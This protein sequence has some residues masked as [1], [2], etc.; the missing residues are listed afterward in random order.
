LF[1]VRDPYNN[2]F[3]II[4][5]STW[6]KNENKLT[7]GTY[8]AVIG[9]TDMNRSIDFYS[10]I[11][12]YDKVVFDQSTV[13]TEFK[14]IPGGE[15]KLRRV[16]LTHSQ[17]RLGA[18]S[19]LFGDTQIELIQALDRQPTKIFADRLWGDLGFIHLCFDMTGM[20]LM[21]EACKKAGCPFTVDTGDSFDMG[22]ASGAFSY[23]EDPDG[24]LIEFVETHKIPVI[25]KLGFYISLRKRNPKKPL[26]KWML[27]A[28]GMNRANDIKFVP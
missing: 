15:S 3:Q 13:F 12:G 22:E 2:L 24:T 10:K 21:R 25:K 26:P 8:G 19:V 28:M 5:A 14:D 4:S 6:F 27:F 9:V 18:F 7:G 1:Y 17:P 11:L 20:S 16:I 23:I